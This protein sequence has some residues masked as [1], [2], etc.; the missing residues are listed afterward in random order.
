[1][2]KQVVGKKVVKKLSNLRAA[3][4]PRTRCYCS[5]NPDVYKSSQFDHESILETPGIS[6][7]SLMSNDSNSEILTSRILLAAL[8]PKFVPQLERKKIQLPY[9]LEV[10]KAIHHFTLT[11]VCKFDLMNLQG[12][13]LAA[14]KFDII[15]IKVQAAKYL[16]ESLQISNALEHYHLSLQ[17]LCTHTKNQTMEFILEN[18]EEL[19]QNEEFLKSCK[20]IWMRKFIEEETLNASEEN[21]FKI[22]VNWAQYDLE[23]EQAIITHIAAH[24]RFELMDQSFFNDVV[25]ACSFLQNSPYLKAAER[26]VQNKKRIG[27]PRKVRS[28]IPGELVFAVGQNTTILIFNTRTNR[29]CLDRKSVFPAHAF[30]QPEFYGAVALDGKLVI[31]GGKG[32]FHYA[33]CM[34]LTTNKWTKSEEQN[35]GSYGSAVVEL[36]GKV[37]CLGG[38]SR[39]VQ[40]FDPITNI[41]TTVRPMNIRRPGACAVAC[42]NKIF[43]LGGEDFT[44][45]IVH[46]SVEIY[47]PETD[48]WTFGPPL[49]QPRRWHKAVVL[50][51]KIFVIGGFNQ[52]SVNIVETLDLSN[53]N[54][55][56]RQINE[57]FRGA[58]IFGVTVLN[59]RIMVTDPYEGT[60]IYS[61]KT[62]E[63]TH[64][65]QPMAL[66]R[67]EN[68]TSM[69]F[70]LTLVTVKGL[71]NRRNYI[72]Q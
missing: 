64:H 6:D 21:V 56:W 40:Y 3:K 55:A 37:Y 30:G 32:S 71:A 10:V 51:N 61:D 44:D 5:I 20:P 70:H 28:R 60:K 27:R 15:G 31:I 8:G 36:G 59:K 49:L 14:K 16:V 43:V 69:G 47:D 25:K 63:W 23:N 58:L 24:I 11:G 41:W 35:G 4:K 7:V 29:W 1:M 54:A 12:L 26:L 39:R 22:L 52:T 33:Y 13:L 57:N 66:K 34:D 2:R 46:Q 9:P 68:I 50:N 18:F 62:N 42:D 19:G 45:Q 17:F 67:T 48:Q 53:P 65:P 38:L 72:S